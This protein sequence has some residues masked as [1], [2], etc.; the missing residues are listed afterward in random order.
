[1]NPKFK[2]DYGYVIE[3]ATGNSK[4]WKALAISHSRAG[5]ELAFARNQ[6]EYNPTTNGTRLMSAETLGGQ[7]VR[8]GV[9]LRIRT[10]PF[11]EGTRT[12]L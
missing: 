11:Y 5:A 10:L 9:Y 6:K 3:V 1:M 2:P 4:R 7:E 8:E 12:V